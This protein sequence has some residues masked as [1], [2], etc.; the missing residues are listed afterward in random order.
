MARALVRG[1]DSSWVHNLYRFALK[2]DAV[3]YL[4]IGLAELIPRA[5]FSRGFDYWES[6]M[7]LHPSEDMYESFCKYQTALMAQL[8]GLAQQYDFEVLDGA[9]TEEAVFEHLRAGIRQVLA[10]ADTGQEKTGPR[11][12]PLE[13]EE[14]QGSPAE[15]AAQQ[16]PRGP[17]AG[18]PDIPLPHRDSAELEERKEPTQ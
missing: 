8:D 2:P 13:A 18:A 3:F 17:K 6:G 14:G 5:V 10:R 16:V 15:L 11:R 12:K 9:R 7:D 1:I 4:R